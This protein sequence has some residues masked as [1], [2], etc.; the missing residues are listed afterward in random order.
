[1]FADVGR[2]GML[3][4]IKLR[5]TTASVSRLERI[6][7]DERLCEAIHTLIWDIDIWRMGDGVQVW[8][9]WLTYC[10]SEAYRVRAD[11]DHSAL[12][13]E[14]AADKEYYEAYLMHLNDEAEAIEEFGETLLRKPM[15]CL[16]LPN[17]QNIHITCNRQQTTKVPLTVPLI[18]CKGDH[19]IDRD[20]FVRSSAI[21]AAIASVKEV[22]FD[23]LNVLG[24][25]ILDT[26]FNLSSR[27]ANITSITIQP[28]A[29]RTSHGPIKHYSELTRCMGCWRNLR[30][31]HLDFGSHEAREQYTPSFLQYVRGAIGLPGNATN[32][33]CPRGPVMWPELRGM[34]LR[35]FDTTYN[36]LLSLIARHSSKL[37][38][39]KLHSTTL[40]PE[41][42]DLVPRYPWPQVFQIIGS[43]TDS[44]RVVLLGKFSYHSGST[45]KHSLD[46]D[47]ASVARTVASRIIDERKR[48]LADDFWEP[49]IKTNEG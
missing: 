40:F 26:S 9:Q 22:W 45:T 7:E 19:V 5:F 12:Y 47:D 8:N 32:S 25:H 36:T 30:L 48:P 42:T 20:D 2:A 28:G 14:L 43:M 27:N 33:R 13:K 15:I 11:P 34:T 17:L 24:L 16:G 23:G 1:M 21:L 4:I 39:L 35:H 49:D 37:R 29:L 10:E 38:E 31:I 46:F 3:G 41:G 6:T 18:A 44:D